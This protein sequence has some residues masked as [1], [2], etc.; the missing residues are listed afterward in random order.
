MT[1][2]AKHTVQRYRELESD[3]DPR[4]RAVGSVEVATTPERWNDLKGP[5]LSLMGRRPTRLPRSA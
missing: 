4:L 2:F 1:E 3:S 5:T